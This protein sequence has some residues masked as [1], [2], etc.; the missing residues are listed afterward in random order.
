MKEFD[1]TLEYDS[2]LELCV[3]QEQKIRKQEMDLKALEERLDETIIDN[4][5]MEPHAR[6]GKAA[7]SAICNYISAVEARDTCK[8]VK[9]F[10][11]LWE[12]AEREGGKRK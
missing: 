2:L 10:S 1:E 4:I 7:I 11:E 9:H 6:Q 3:S 12:I 8:R 5:R